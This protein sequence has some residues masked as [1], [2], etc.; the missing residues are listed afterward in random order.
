MQQKK[1]Q[2][3]KEAESKI[4]EFFNLFLSMIQIKRSVYLRITW[5]LENDDCIYQKYNKK[6]KGG[7]FFIQKTMILI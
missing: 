4:Q 2:V 7:S 5:E 3:F 6:S 1:Y